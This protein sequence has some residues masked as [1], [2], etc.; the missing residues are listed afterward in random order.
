MAQ[1][2]SGFGSTGASGRD[3]GDGVSRRGFVA[4]GAVATGV[5][6]AGLARSANV[7]GSDRLKVGLVGCG[8]RGLG[9]G[10]QAM[11]A[12]PGA[13][14]W[15]LADPF[16]EKP[17]QAANVL[18]RAVAEKTKD[19]PAYAQRFDC[20]ADRWFTGLDGY[21]R[22]IDCCDVVLLCSPTAFRPAQL[23]AAVEA[24]RHVFCEKPVA[25]DATA[26]RHVRE[27]TQ[28]AR[29]KKLSLVSGFVWRYTSRMR[30]AFKQIADGAIGPVRSA[31]T[32]YNSTGY[33]GE[34]PRK[35][36][37]TDMEYQIRNWQYY[38]WLSGDH[39]TEQAIHM[40]DRLLWAF[41]DE[42][43]T[44]VVCTGGREVRG[45]APAGNNIFDHF[46]AAFEFEG[47]RRGFHMCR[48]FPN[49]PVDVSDFITGTTGTAEINGF[50]NSQRFTTPARTWESEAPKNDGYQQEHDDLFAG[51]RDGKPIDDGSILV[52][53]NALALMAR[54]SAYTGQ[55]VTLEQLWES[56]EDLVP[57]TI[58]L[59]A[60]PPPTPIAVPGKTRLL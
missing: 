23:R 51:I 13:V 47:G 58:S 38:T 24:G 35:P 40:L 26:L 31:Y 50:K 28:I 39:I 59:D 3:A 55:R 8:G 42:M 46:V 36:G 9:A 57:E 12:D 29:D 49:C 43:P 22:L 27:S 14:L 21:R 56:K 33:R 7:A 6:S 4:A 41:G 30:D 53:S 48:H 15:A 2:S 52:N 16:P 10:A 1:R 54:M 5:L 37:W 20:P 32:T 18:S 25:V 44:G 60:P 17:Q 45:D 11:A 19:D 34:V